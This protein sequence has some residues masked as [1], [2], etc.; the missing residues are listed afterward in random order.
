MLTANTVSYI[1]DIVLFC[2]LFLWR[3]GRAAVLISF[4]QTTRIL[5]IK[6]RTNIA[7]LY[8]KQPI[9]IL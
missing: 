8:N 1:L 4:L 6:A 2:F 5:K 9:E 7:I 3:R